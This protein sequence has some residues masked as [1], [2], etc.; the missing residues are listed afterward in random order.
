MMTENQSTLMVVLMIV[1]RQ[2]QDGFVSEELSLQHQFVQKSA[3]MLSEQ[4]ERVAMME[5]LLI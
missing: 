2:P 4:A 3:E 1:Q 5:T